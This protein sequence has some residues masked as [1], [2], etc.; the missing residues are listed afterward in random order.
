M[1]PLKIYDYLIQSRKRVLNAVRPLTPQQYRHPFGFGLKTI[2]S[3]LTHMMISEWYYFERFEGRAVPP[4]ERWPIQYENPPEFAVVERTWPDQ[5]R[6]ISALIAGERDWNRTITYDSFP[7]EQGRR[8][9]ITA[10]SGDFLTQL[11]LHEVHHRAQLMAMLREFGD[12]VAPLQDI[13]F[14]DLMYQR[15]EIS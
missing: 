10:T 6:R 15:R 13:D 7:D 1:N 5:T 8:F 11:A 9:R 4:Y 12:A 3:T 14:N 2:G